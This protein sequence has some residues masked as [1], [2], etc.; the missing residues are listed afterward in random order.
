[1][2]VVCYFD[3]T[4]A[5]SL[6][7]WRWIETQVRGGEV[8]VDVEWRTFSLKEQNSAEGTSIF[9]EGAETSLSLLALALS[10]AAR[11]HDFRSFHASVFETF[12]DPDHRTSTDRLWDIAEA[13]GVDVQRFRGDRADWIARV[14][15]EH[16][17]AVTRYGVFGTPTLI[18]D[19]DVPVYLKMS[20]LPDSPAEGR[21]LWD[22]LITLAVLHPEVL[23]MKR[24]V[25]VDGP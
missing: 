16:R 2:R 9:Q 6:R 3:Y 23:E 25:P 22:A 13:S 11:Q 17:T 1:M 20:R 7:A 4:C 18:F 21:R 24:P 10:H 5:Y 12:H 15:D 8:D 14:A 19:K